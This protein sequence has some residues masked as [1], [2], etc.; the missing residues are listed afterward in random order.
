[1]QE[2]RPDVGNVDK[3]D[4]NKKGRERSRSE[5]REKEPSPRRTKER[6]PRGE[7]RVIEGGKEMRE[8]GI[9]YGI[10]IGKRD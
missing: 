1:M 4:T 3:Y 8:L 9:R 5:R 6:N 10:K 7:I 2:T